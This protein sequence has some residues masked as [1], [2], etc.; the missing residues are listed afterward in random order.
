M[1]V[2]STWGTTPEERVFSFPCDRLLPDGEALYRGIT[3]DA[4]P[5]LVFRW[6]CQMRVAPYSYD[7]LDNRG[8]RSPRE[9]AP[10]LDE[11]EVGQV[12]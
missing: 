8:R 10:R 3:I 4:P 1:S 6:L 2:A 12:F 11:L 5:S 7:R 9:L